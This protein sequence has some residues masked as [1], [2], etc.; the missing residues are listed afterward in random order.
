MDVNKKQLS[1]VGSTPTTEE[2]S[3]HDGYGAPRLYIPRSC[4]EAGTGAHRYCVQ[5]EESETA[6]CAAGDLLQLRAHQIF[7]G[8][9]LKLAYKTRRTERPVNFGPN[10][11]QSAGGF[12]PE[13]REQWFL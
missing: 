7:G 1:F 13:G 4:I 12:S 9:I 8:G 6:V 10:D 2:R 5:D 11:A 3:G